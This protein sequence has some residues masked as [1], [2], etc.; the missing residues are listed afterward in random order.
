[1]CIKYSVDAYFVIPVNQHGNQTAH[2][3][4]LTRGQTPNAVDKQHTT[5]DQEHTQHALHL[6]FA[7]QSFKILHTE[8]Q[9]SFKQKTFKEL[10]ATARYYYSQTLEELER[11]ES[12]GINVE[13][14]GM[15][16]EHLCTYP[17]LNELQQ[18][19]LHPNYFWSCQELL[20]V[21]ATSWDSPVPGFFLALPTY[22]DSWVDSDLTTHS[23]R[24]YFLCYNLLHE[25]VVETIPQ[26]MHFSNHQGYNLKRPLEFFQGHGNYVL[27]VL[28]MVKR[29]YSIF[30][31]E[32]P[33]LDV[34]KILWNYVPKSLEA[35]SPRTP[36][37]FSSTKPSLIS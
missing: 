15:T 4:Q 6:D 10:G 32:V 11:L 28:Q 5:A 12:Q 9:T 14:D 2:N 35:A 20:E 25:G 31:Y 24:L 21:S 16:K 34:F 8:A 36:L 7:L 23:F 19:I 18:K 33:P 37:D 27:K 3:I 17:Y 13:V 22:L 29:G 1:L 26:S 30:N